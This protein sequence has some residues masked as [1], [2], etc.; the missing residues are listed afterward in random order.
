MRSVARPGGPHPARARAAR[1]AVHDTA[2]GG[3]VDDR[4]R[5]RRP[6]ST[7]AASRRTTPPTW[8]TPRPTSPSTCSTGPGAT[9][10]TR[11]PTSRTS[12]TSTTRC[13]SGPTQGGVDWRELAE[14]ETEL[15]RE[16]M[17]ALRVLPPDAL[18]RRRRVDPAGD[19]ADRAAR[20]GRL[21]VYR[22]RRT[23]STSRSTADPDVRRASRAATASQ[24]LA[25]FAER[26]GDPDRAGQAGPARLRCSGAPSAGRAGLGQRR[27]AAGRPGWHI[28]CT[29]IALEHLGTAFDVQ[30]GGTDLVF[31]HHEMCAGARPGRR[32]GAAVRPGLRARR[33]GRLRRREDVEV[34]GQ[35]GLRLRACAQRRRPD[36]DPAGPA[37]PPLPHRLGV[38]RRR[39]LG[40]RRHARPLAPRAVRCGAGAP[41][42]ARWSTRSSPRWPT[43]STPPR[44]SPRSTPGSR[45]PRHRPAWPTPLTRTPRRRCRTLLDAALGL[46]L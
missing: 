39:A 19:R 1:C 21:P 41:A 36:G 34:A 33:H 45:H 22:G 28:E 7:S 20:G 15:F 25:V 29:A 30:G 14:R 31:P 42:A 46:S 32:P 2:T 13:W 44:R 24:M 6:G 11:S 23:T 18:R 17:E 43:T 5:G 4:A 9:P 26:G 37:A 38:D 3:L 40:R 35:P 12:P 16:D 27:S 8:A 10:A